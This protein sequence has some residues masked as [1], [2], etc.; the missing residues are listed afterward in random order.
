MSR[1]DDN[2]AKAEALVFRWAVMYGLLSDWYEDR[3]E[4]PPGCLEETKLARLWG[5]YESEL[6]QAVRDLL[7]QT[8]LRSE[9]LKRILRDVE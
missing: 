2:L 5:R 6:R 4:A 7:K 9:L 3:L 1:K 8:D